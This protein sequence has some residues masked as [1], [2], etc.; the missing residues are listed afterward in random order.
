MLVQLQN[1]WLLIP[2]Y[3]HIASNEGGH[4]VVAT[5]RHVSSRR[6]FTAPELLA[7]DIL[8]IVASLTLE[9]VFNSAWTNYQENGNWS[10]GS[11]DAHAH[12]H[13]YGRHPAALNQPF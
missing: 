4:L 3:A 2:N 5:N 6:D 11:T 9:T 10:I 1:C 12:L 7:T 8:A 13:V